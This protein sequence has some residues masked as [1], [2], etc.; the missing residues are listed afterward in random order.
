MATFNFESALQANEQTLFNSHDNSQLTLEMQ[1]IVQQKLSQYK[2]I[3]DMYEGR[4]REF[5]S[6]EFRIEDLA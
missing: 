2:E 4:E 3:V 1:H 5:I 6:K